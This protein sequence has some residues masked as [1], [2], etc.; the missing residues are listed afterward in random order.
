MRPESIPVAK[1]SSLVSVPADRAMTRNAPFDG[2]HSIVLGDAEVID[3]PVVDPNA[4]IPR[5]KAIMHDYMK[6]KNDKNRE[7]QDFL[8]HRAV[9]AV[10]PV[11]PTI[12]AEPRVQDAPLSKK[13]KTKLR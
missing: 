6:T 7:L 3:Y 10:P 2:L 11:Q 9:P 8:I 1:N 5:S 12:N 4:S 13:L